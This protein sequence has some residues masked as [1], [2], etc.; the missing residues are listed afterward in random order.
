MLT[1]RRRT[2]TLQERWIPKDTRRTISRHCGQS[3]PRVDR[4][5]IEVQRG[6]DEHRALLSCKIGPALATAWLL[7]SITSPRDDWSELAS[8]AA[9]LAGITDPVHLQRLQTAVSELGLEHYLVLRGTEVFIYKRLPHFEV[10]T[11]QSFVL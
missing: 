7:R 10:E 3:N 6:R 1:R 4:V 5:D 2:S 11:L 9:E 8:L